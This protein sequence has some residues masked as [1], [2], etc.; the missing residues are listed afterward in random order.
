MRRREFLGLSGCVVGGMAIRDLRAQQAK[1]PVVGFLSGRSPEDSIYV[2]AAFRRGLRESGFVD[3]HNVA[4]EFRW[5]RGHYNEL[6]AMTADLVNRQVDVLAAVGGATGAQNAAKL[7]ST[8]IPVVFVMGG[9]PV[10]AGLV[11]SFN[12]PGGNVTGSV[13]LGITE[14]EPKKFGL[15]RELVPG[16]RNIGAVFDSNFYAS[17]QQL[18]QLRE[19]AQAVDQQITIAKVGNDTELDNAF[20]MLAREQVSALL[21]AASAY[22][23]TR[24]DRFIAFATKHRL[25]AM[26]Q[27]RE[28]AVAGG[29]ISYGPSFADAYR[30]AGA[31]TGR[32]LKRA[33]PADLP[34]VRSSRFELVINLKVAKSI[35]LTI[36]HTLLARADDVIE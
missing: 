34:V 35:G 25:P 3:G 8:T 29:L 10:K 28:F 13:I 21:I 27:F 31:Y 26:Y 5:A 24:Q 36:P 30:Q 1:V 19:A 7:S 11:K 15:L 2:L 4:I 6:P 23:D 16:I 20:A 32:I 14:M 9:D 33:R 22:F 12:R 18:N 17:S